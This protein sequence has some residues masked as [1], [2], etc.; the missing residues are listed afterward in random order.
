[1]D[2][3]LSEMERNNRADV[4]FTGGDL[5]RTA[6]QAEG[7]VKSIAGEDGVL[8]VDLTSQTGPLLRPMHDLPV[9]VLLYARPYSGWSCGRAAVGAERQEG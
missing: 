5:I 8:I 7:F 4:R 2:A 9:P 1:M 3:I 6:E